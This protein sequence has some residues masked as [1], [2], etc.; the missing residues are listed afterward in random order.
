MLYLYTYILKY[1]YVS[2][3]RMRSIVTMSIYYRP[4]LLSQV[5]AVESIGANVRKRITGASE[6]KELVSHKQ[7]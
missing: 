1:T 5:T 4:L 2:V 7:S 3:E 6:K